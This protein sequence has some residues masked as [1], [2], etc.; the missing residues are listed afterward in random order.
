MKNANH[1]ETIVKCYRC[2]LGGFFCE[3]PAGGDYTTCPLC[4]YG[5]YTHIDQKCYDYVN[6]LDDNDI[7]AQYEFC[8]TCLIMYDIGCTHAENGCTDCIY[9]GH[10]IARW[11]DKTSGHVYDGMPQFDTVE[12][13][14]AD[15][16]KVEILKMVCLNN[17]HHCTNAHYPHSRKCDDTIGEPE[18]VTCFTFPESKKK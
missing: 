17:G 2:E 8:P 15:A 1:I 7:H 10:V 18:I 3:T 5:D 4:S 14:V 13:W 16:N 11:R 12:E 9:N 6:S